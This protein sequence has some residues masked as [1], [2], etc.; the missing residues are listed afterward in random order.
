MPRK[1]GIDIKCI[2]GSNKKFK[3]CC[4]NDTKAS[5]G[6]EELD[7]LL[8][9]VTIGN[10]ILSPS[11][12]N[13]FIEETNKIINQ[14]AFT[15]KELQGIYLHYSQILSFSGYDKQALDIIN[16]MNIDKLDMLSKGLFSVLRIKSLINL[17]K[18]IEALDYMEE[19]YKLS[20]EIEWSDDDSQLIKCN[21]LL[22]LA[23]NVTKIR[24]LVT[25]YTS[26]TFD[27]D[28]DLDIY[29]YL[30]ESYKYKKYEDFNTYIGSVSNRASVKLSSTIQKVQEEGEQ[31]LKEAIN[32]KIN[33]GYWEGV[34]NNYNML[35]VYYMRQK[36][37][38]QAFAHLKKDIV[39]T[40]KY[41]SQHDLA[42]SLIVLGNCYL[43]VRDY[44]QSRKCIYDAKKIA[45][46]TN[47]SN[48][49]KE[50]EK[51]LNIIKNIAKKANEE[52]IP[53][54][55]NAECACGSREKYKNCCGKA[56]V[57]Y[58]S[59][60]KVLGIPSILPYA[61]LVGDKGNDEKFI[62][63]DSEIDEV[64]RVLDNEVRFSWY[65]IESNNAYQEIFELPDMASMH[66]SSAK[67]LLSNFTTQNLLEEVSVAI[68]TCLLSVSALEAFMNQLVYFS[69]S[70]SSLEMP[71]FIQQNM[72]SELS[73]L[74]S[75]Q[76]N[77]RFT[78]KINQMSNLFCNGKWSKK[79]FSKYDDLFKVISIRNELVHFKSL[80]YHQV[81]PEK[82]LHRILKNL[83]N[84]VVLRDVSNA[85]TLKLLNKSFAEWCYATVEEAIDYIKITFKEAQRN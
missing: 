40:K 69:S 61:K 7:L 16:K 41:G 43:E 33:N 4:M 21:L 50:C 44:T 15:S 47:N 13:I 81:L 29:E 8:R 46:E 20:K 9:E 19:A 62:K 42:L 68:S 31:E 35:G 75:Y 24:S 12:L 51:N 60:E 1:K 6:Y 56:D 71:Q 85:W 76:R 67:I 18:Y 57:E 73:D 52:G 3:N 65:K 30:I 74:E 66:L 72:I 22:E 84:N 83:P 37:Y 2:C 53:F 64:L 5:K 77:T 25:N 39:L 14:S 38:L 55:K 23:K 58:E 11:E 17:S 26:D 28:M 45:N 63:S 79:D 78:D 32:E 54:G 49:I 10:I 59:F 27:Y 34:A 48:L 80:E 82:S 70:N 36:N